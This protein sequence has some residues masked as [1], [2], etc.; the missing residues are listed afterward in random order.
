MEAWLARLCVDAN[1][2]IVEDY[3]QGYDPA[4][5]TDDFT[6]DGWC[7]GMVIDWLRCRH[8]NRNFW[9]SFS[10]DSGRSR[11]RFIMARQRAIDTK[12]VVA[13]RY[14][15]IPRAMQQAG[16]TL[17][18]SHE[19]LDVG[20]ISAQAIC[21]TVMQASGRYHVIV[22]GGVGGRHAVGIY[23]SITQIVFMDPNAGEF[24]FSTYQHLRKWLPVFLTGMGYAARDQ[25]ESLRVDSFG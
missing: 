8:W 10:T 15:K 1:V 12:S 24:V 23:E 9:Q 17:Q 4:A 2:E 7:L 18:S 20:Q 5:L 14:T 13:D 22:I 19:D 11:V 21:A 3:Q 25:L 16:L 6:A